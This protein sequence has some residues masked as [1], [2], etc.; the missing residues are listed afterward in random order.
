MLIDA[1]NNEAQ[2]QQYIIDGLAALG[3]DNKPIS[4]LIITHG[5]GDHYGGQSLRRTV[6]Y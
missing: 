1:L 5:H 2:A 3:L 6:T 4:H